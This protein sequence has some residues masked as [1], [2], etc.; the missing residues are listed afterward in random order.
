MVH[1]GVSIGFSVDVVWGFRLLS[2]GS[3]QARKALGFT[4]G[5]QL[6]DRDRTLT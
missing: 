6:R 5:A 4:M 2:L 1:V 3:C